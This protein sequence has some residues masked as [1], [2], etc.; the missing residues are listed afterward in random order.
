MAL[1]SRTKAPTPSPETRVRRLGDG[2]VIDGEKRWIGNAVFADYIVVWARD[3]HDEVGAY[4][5]RK[6]NPLN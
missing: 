6:E 2:Y 4:V 5:V 1:P 3:A